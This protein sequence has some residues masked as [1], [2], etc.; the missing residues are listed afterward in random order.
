MRNRVEV[1]SWSM[2]SC[3]AGGV[4]KTNRLQDHA[5]SDFAQRFSCIKAVH[6]FGSV[7]RGAADEAGDVDL[8]FEYSDDIKFSSKQVAALPNFK[9]NW[10][11]G[12]CA[13]R[14]SWASPSNHAATTIASGTR[15][16]GK[17]SRPHRRRQ[18][19]ASRLSCLR[20][21]SQNDGYWFLQ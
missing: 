19:L 7:A 15:P 18:H 11:S 10:R 1:R 2:I 12:C 5:L 6:L 14:K 13:R 21:P 16:F 8:F 20:P 9:I 3:S 4:R 17:Q